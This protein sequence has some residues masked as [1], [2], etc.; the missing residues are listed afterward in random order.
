[1]GRHSTYRA[2]DVFPVVFSTCA[3]LF[4][5]VAGTGAKGRSD[6]TFGTISTTAIR[7]RF[8]GGASI[9]ELPGGV[10]DADDRFLA[11]C[12]AGKILVSID[13]ISLSARCDRCDRVTGFIVDSSANELT[14]KNRIVNIRRGGDVSESVS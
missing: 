3:T 1:M 12:E 14:R 2:N 13:M 7:C 6:S 8:D 9:S 11:S 10:N 4:S 5:V